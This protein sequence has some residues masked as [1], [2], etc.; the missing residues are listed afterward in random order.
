[1]T[2]EYT[3]VFWEEHES[4]LLSATYLPLVLGAYM[5][6]PHLSKVAAAEFI[7]LVNDSCYAAPK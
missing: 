4:S 7:L 2:L 1:M 3:N 6:V 5:R